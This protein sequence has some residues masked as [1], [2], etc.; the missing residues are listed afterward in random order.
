MLVIFL[1]I[2]GIRVACSSWSK[3]DNGDRTVTI[4]KQSKIFQCYICQGEREKTELFSKQMKRFTL[5]TI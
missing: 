2:G 4:S 3:S 5:Y 1:M